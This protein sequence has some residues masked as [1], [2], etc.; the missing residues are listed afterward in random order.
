MTGADPRG[1]YFVSSQYTAEGTAFG[2][3]RGFGRLW[4]EDSMVEPPA[5]PTGWERGAIM[6]RSQPAFVL[7][8]LGPMWDMADPSGWRPNI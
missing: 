4:N 7:T 3:T 2:D 5:D 8:Q 1:R 6:R